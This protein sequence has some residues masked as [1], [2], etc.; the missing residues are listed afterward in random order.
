MVRSHILKKNQ[1]GKFGFG[2]TMERIQISKVKL[3]VTT[4]IMGI[5]GGGGGEGG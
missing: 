1:W 3:C 2:T 4:V 5:W